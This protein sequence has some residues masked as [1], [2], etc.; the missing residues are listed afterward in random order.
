MKIRINNKDVEC[1]TFAINTSNNLHCNYINEEI[2][3][4]IHP[5]NKFVRN[6]MSLMLSIEIDEPEHKYKFDALVHSIDDLI[7]GWIH[8]VLIIPPELVPTEFD[9]SPLH[10]VFH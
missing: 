6:F 3:M 2:E 1:G 8:I 10:A 9:Y 7:D 4:T 5:S